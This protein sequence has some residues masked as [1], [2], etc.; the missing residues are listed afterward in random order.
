M[1]SL[2]LEQQNEIIKSAANGATYRH[3]T[4]E[5]S[6]GNSTIS[7]YTSRDHLLFRM[8]WMYRDVERLENAIKTFTGIVVILSLS[9]VVLLFTNIFY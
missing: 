7:K 9:V 2:T 3:M 1:E 4:H 8:K 5:M 6:Y